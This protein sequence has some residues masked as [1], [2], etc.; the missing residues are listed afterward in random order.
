MAGT[1]THLGVFQAPLGRIGPLALVVSRL[2]RYELL[3]RRGHSL[4]HPWTDT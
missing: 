1:W 2:G 4:E 3:I